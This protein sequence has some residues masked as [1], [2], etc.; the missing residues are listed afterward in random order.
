MNRGVARPRRQVGIIDIWNQGFTFKMIIF[1]SFTSAFKLW[2]HVIL[3]KQLSLS[4][5]RA[6]NYWNSLTWPGTVGKGYGQIVW[7]PFPYPYN[8]LVIISLAGG[9]VCQKRGGGSQD[10]MLSRTPTVNR[11]QPFRIPVKVS[12]IFF[13]LNAMNN[14]RK[15]LSGDKVRVYS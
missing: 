10:W 11:T 3:A 9:W 14:P 6:L 15:S 1:F 4:I 7:S 13:G 8:K 5:L 12:K 2:T